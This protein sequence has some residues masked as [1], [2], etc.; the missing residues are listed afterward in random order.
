MSGANL[1]IRRSAFPRKKHQTGFTLLEV[2]IALVLLSMMMVAVVAA[3]RTFGNTKA[4]LETVTGRIDE[5]RLVSD[6]LR[7][8][9]EGTLPVVRV[10]GSAI[11]GQFEGGTGDTFFSGN[12]HSM[13]WVAPMVAGANLGGTFVMRLRRVDDRLE[14]SWRPYQRN[15]AEFEEAELT[16]RVLLDSVEQFSISYRASHGGDWLEEWGGHQF[17]PAAVRLNIRA[18]ERYWPELVIRMAGAPVNVQ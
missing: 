14:L 16:P 10:G 12:T 4:T 6:F 7:N 18:N 3:M 11:D 5:I 8:S 9:L 1:L 13:V 2:L 17:I 15:F